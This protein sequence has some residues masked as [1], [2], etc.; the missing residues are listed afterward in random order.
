MVLNEFKNVKKDKSKYL[1]EV[2]IYLNRTIAIRFISNS[3]ELEKNWD[4]AQLELSSIYQYEGVSPHIWD[5]YLV[6][7]CQFSDDD[8]DKRLRFKIESDRFC[9]RKFFVFGIDPKTF[10]IDSLVNTLFPVIRP[11]RQIQLIKPEV[12]LEK[13]GSEFNDLVPE[14]FFTEELNENDLEP[15]IEKII[16]KGVSSNE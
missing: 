8:L 3:D 1:N 16:A 13:L 2:Y 15:L 5:Y 4:E 7:C 11:T 14:S 6:F 10:K 12:V 9:C